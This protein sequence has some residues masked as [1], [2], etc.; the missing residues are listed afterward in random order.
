MNETY[1]NRLPGGLAG[2]LVA[3]WQS[4]LTAIETNYNAQQHALVQRDNES[5]DKSADGFV[6]MARG[7]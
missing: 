7:L 5:I 2:D 3:M 6:Q 1:A 4:E